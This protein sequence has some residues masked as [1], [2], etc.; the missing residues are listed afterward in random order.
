[1]GTHSLAASMRLLLVSISIS[2]VPSSLSLCMIQGCN[3]WWNGGAK[4]DRKIT[5]ACAVLFDE[6]CCKSSK[7]FHV[8]AKGEEGKLC[9]VVSNLNPL[10]SCQGPRIKDDIESLVVM[11]GCT[12]E[13]W[14]K[15]NGLSKAQSQERKSFNAG[16]YKD[17]VDRYKRNKL[18]FSAQQTLHMVEE[19]NDDLNDIIPHIRRNWH[20]LLNVLKSINLFVTNAKNFNPCES[21]IF[22][23]LCQ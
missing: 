16:N 23:S 7:T 19:L 10:S 11:P 9:G 13:V 21:Q 6:N 4:T 20:T 15:R 17:N 1:M 3:K 8:V 5:G 2:L 14:D 18:V 12:L 22:W